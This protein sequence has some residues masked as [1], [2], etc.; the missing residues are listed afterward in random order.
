[1][2]RTL[3]VGAARGLGLGHGL[4]A[5]GADVTARSARRLV[6]PM[7]R[8]R[9]LGARAGRDRRLVRHCG[10]SL[11][12]QGD[13]DVAVGQH[14]GPDLLGDVGG[15][16]DAHLAERVLRYSD[17]V[18][19]LE[20]GLGG[21]GDV[22]HVVACKHP[23]VLYAQHEAPMPRDGLCLCGLLTHDHRAGGDRPDCLQ[24]KR[25]E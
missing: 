21:V 9:P 14:A 22:A 1:M 12:V 15:E 23:T 5:E 16:S 10:V 7:L 13:R 8:L 2:A 25:I 17:S 11:V 4:A 19:V 3:R 24:T 18:F 6:V 20:D